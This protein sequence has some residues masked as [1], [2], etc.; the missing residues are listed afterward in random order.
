[1]LRF[2][3][4]REYRVFTHGWLPKAIARLLPGAPV[5]LW[6]NLLGKQPLLE[7]ATAE[8]YSHLWGEY[9]WAKRTKGGNSGEQLLRVYEVALVLGR[10]PALPAPLEAPPVP[11]AVVAGYD[12]EAQGGRWGDHPH[13]KPFGVIEPLV[14]QYSRPGG[15]VLDPFAGS[16]SIP[17]AALLLGRK[18]ACIEL[19]PEWA[20]RVNERLLEEATSR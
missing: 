16:G 9:V 17:S 2:E 20:R 3:N 19:K 4:V 18:A 11:W 12:D 1:M 10:V 7:I 8:G 5:I 13:H 6:T 15:L 14:R